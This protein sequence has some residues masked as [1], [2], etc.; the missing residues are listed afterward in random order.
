[1]GGNVQ[2]PETLTTV[3]WH[4]WGS[5]GAPDP[6][7]SLPPSSPGLFAEAD[8]RGERR[9]KG[10]KRTGEKNPSSEL[11]RELTSIGFSSSPP[12]PSSQ[13]LAPQHMLRPGL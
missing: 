10:E 6:P 5:R 9:D 4:P 3:H 1:M 12:P 8:L 11:K 13:H 7:F 2:G